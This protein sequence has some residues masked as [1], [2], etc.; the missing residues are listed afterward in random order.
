MRCR[1]QQHA[2]REEVGRRAPAAAQGA[3]DTQKRCDVII[4][5]LMSPPVPVC[6]CKPPCRPAKLRGEGG[7]HALGG[8]S[9]RH[10]RHPPWNGASLNPPLSV[11]VRAWWASAAPARFPKACSHN[12]VTV[13]AAIAGLGGLTA[14]DPLL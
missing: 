5:K 10:C 11:F 13:G 4:L 6:A 14:T 7:G 3:L 2:R 12:Q 9:S 8:D 1:R